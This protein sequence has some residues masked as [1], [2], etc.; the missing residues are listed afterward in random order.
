[1]PPKKSKADALVPIPSEVERR[2]HVVRGVRVMLD[3]ELAELYGVPTKVLNQAVERNAQRFPADF[4][5]HLTEYE[6]ANLKSQ[7]VTS[8]SGHGG[9]RKPPRAFTEEGVAMLSSVLRSDTAVRVNIAIMRAFVR[10]R[11][12]L[13]TPGE[14]V[15]Q[16]QQ[17]A[18][19]VQIHD[20]QIKAIIDALQ[21]MLTPPPDN[22][23]KRR[24]G[25]IDT[26]QPSTETSS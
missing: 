5:F 10:L 9:R 23:P 19:S 8:K 16:L 1:M 17:L 13:A 18:E 22:T 11:R 4:S 7:I 20:T 15:T 2:I 6:V 3:G 26:D 12:L 25:F 14:I 21:K 24:I